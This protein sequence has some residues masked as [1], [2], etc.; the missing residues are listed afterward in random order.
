MKKGFCCTAF[1]MRVVFCCAAA[2]I[3]LAGCKSAVTDITYEQM[4]AFTEDDE[5][6]KAMAVIDVREASKWSA[7]SI[8]YS[9]N[10]AADDFLDADGKPE[11]G[12]S[13]L[14][15]VVA[16]KRTPLIVYGSG[17]GEAQRFAAGAAWL[18][19]RNVYLYSGGTADW[20][21]QGDYYVIAYE[22]F[23][24]WYDETC[25]FDD[26]EN[27][28]IDLYRPEIYADEYPLIAT[29][30]IAGAI[31]VYDALFIAGGEIIDEGRALTEVVTDKEARLV[32]YCGGGL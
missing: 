2:G 6:V 24:K 30:H 19:Y 23:I 5:G 18:G 28:L 16:D 8:Q 25:P 29:G 14:T 3:F 32:L 21:V 9:V 10:I 26:G 7:G 31:N 13:A 1:V 12:G 20:D 11:N 15:S 4:K 17:G 22:D 27:Y